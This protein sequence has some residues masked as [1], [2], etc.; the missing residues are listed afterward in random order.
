MYPLLRATA[1]EH[2][3]T[4]YWA[5]LGN[6]AAFC[7]LALIIASAMFAVWRWYGQDFITYYVAARLVLTN[8]NPYDY[9]IVVP[10]VL[11]TIGTAGQAAY[12]YAPW[13]VYPLLPLATLPFQA[14]RAIWIIAN[15]LFWIASM[16]LIERVLILELVAWKRW[17]I[18][19][20]TFLLFGWLT[21][22]TEQAAI[23]VLFAGALAF[24]GL[25][26]G[27][28][29]SAAVALAWLFSKPNIT[30][31][32]LLLILVGLWQRNRQLFIAVMLVLIG[33]TAVASIVTPGWW[34][35]IVN[36]QVPP[37]WDHGLDGFTVIGRRVNSTTMDWLEITWGINGTL[38]WLV[39][40]V[41]AGVSGI[42]L[43]YWR[44]DPL[45]VLMLAVP[46][47]FLLAPTAMQYDYA[48]LTIP[49]MWVL[50]QLPHINRIR[51]IIFAI[52]L[53]LLFCVLF[54]ESLVSD[55]VWI[56]IVLVILLL[57]AAPIVASRQP[58]A[59]N[60]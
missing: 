18:W 19:L 33:L 35:P 55:A 15:V 1:V 52:G 12:F 58:V 54:L 44:N 22:R 40:A 6:F 39:F 20:I 8:Q 50:A 45:F 26:R 4:G 3:R 48:L 51:Q 53:V 56:P 17:L 14:A 37:G 25:V 23:S 29:K 30:I 24:W 57:T 7:M 11:Q 43:W 9:R 2:K 21:L 13:W 31:I 46:M 38:A 27:H 49:F 32:P 10:I 5:R 59:S 28:G 41:V 34:G 60:Y 47:G 42:C 16:L 36:G